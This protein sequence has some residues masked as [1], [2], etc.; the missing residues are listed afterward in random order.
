MMKILEEEEEEEE[1]EQEEGVTLY[2]GTNLFLK[3][4][5]L[6]HAIYEIYNLKN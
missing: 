3:F 2:L 6:F 5:N 4:I 1:E